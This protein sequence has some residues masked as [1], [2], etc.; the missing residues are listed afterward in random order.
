MTDTRRTRPEFPR[1]PPA[2]EPRRG[3]LW[4]GIALQLCLLV[5]TLAAF[6]VGLRIVDFREFRATPEQNRLPYDYDAE[7][8]WFGA[9]NKIL[10]ADGLPGSY[11]TS[12]NSLGLRDI[13]PGAAGEQTILVLGDSLVYGTGIAAEQRFTQLLR[14]QL[15]GSRIVNAGVAGFGTDQEYLLLKRLWPI[16]KPDVVVLIVS[17]DSDHWDNSTNSAYGHT[18]KPYL[19]E[20]DSQWQFRGIPVPRSKAYYFD[21]LWPAR[22][23]YVVR[24]AVDF[25]LRARYP[26]V[27]VPDPTVTLVGM[28]RG[29]VEAHGAA[30]LVGLQHQDPT[31]EPFLVSQKIAYV[32]FDDAETLYNDDH[33]SLQG[34]ATVAKELMDLLS[35]EKMIDRRA[36]PE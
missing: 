9:P 28:M 11:R 13:E 26:A 5:A 21:H 7:L 16:I 6:E 22:H 34:N 14:P 18:L 32:G 15:P 27:F 12:L 4:R 36:P 3:A 23:S 35:R 33:W 24:L 20:I 19:A 1:L 17:V 8:G 29:F 25:Y 10:P 30:F 31:L 2:A